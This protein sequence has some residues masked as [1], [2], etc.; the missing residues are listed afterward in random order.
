MGLI[1]P[2]SYSGFISV[3]V[4]NYPHRKLLREGVVYSSLQFQTT[5][6]HSRDVTEAET[7]GSQPIVFIIRKG[8]RMHVCLCLAYLFQ[9]PALGNGATHNR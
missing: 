3:A 2:P 7:G 9:G 5:A 6:S 1:T 4:I 8:Q